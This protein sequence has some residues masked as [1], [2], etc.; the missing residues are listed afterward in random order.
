[1]A[2]RTDDLVPAPLQPDPGEQ[3]LLSQGTGQLRH[4]TVRA[5]EL[6]VAG[7]DTVDLAGPSRDGKRSIRE[8]VLPLGA[9]PD[10]RSI[11]DMVADAVAGRRDT[12]PHRAAS[13]RLRDSHAGA[14]AT[15]VRSAIR[16]SAARV[17]RWFDSGE[18]D[19]QGHRI[20]PSALGPLPVATYVH[21]ASFQLAA[22][23]RAIGGQPELPELEALGLTALVDSAGAVA[24]RVNATAS[25]TAI[26]PDLAVGT[27]AHGGA[28]RT[29]MP[30]PEG[31]GPAVIAS[32]GLIVDIAAGQV[33]LPS[34]LRGLR[35]RDS[36]RL[37]AM[38]VVL[39]GIPDLPAAALLRRAGR[40]AR[41]SAARSTPSPPR[42]TRRDGDG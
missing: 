12:E 38:A 2:D 36:R 6:F 23:W 30:E 3:G 21:A 4:R 37:A 33:D 20:T 22:T 26:T 35:V 39:D 42:R 41:L 25:I 14:T 40:L 17:T 31:P 8:A 24:A 9:W 5:W 18:A 34:V 19:E 28:W 32:A 10:S 15:E 16:T 27:G 7:L 29:A 1:V 11:H 13:A